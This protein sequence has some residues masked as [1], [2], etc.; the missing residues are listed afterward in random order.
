M[1]PEDKENPQIA[2]WT[3]IIQKVIESKD[4]L[5]YK[6]IMRYYGEE[7]IPIMKCEEEYVEW[8]KQDS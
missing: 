8:T 2:E 3:I 6:I 1:D 4:P 5:T 7:P